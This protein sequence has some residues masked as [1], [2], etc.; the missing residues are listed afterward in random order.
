MQSKDDDCVRNYCAWIFFINST[1][2]FGHFLR[3]L[4]YYSTASVVTLTNP[5][6]ILSIISTDLMTKIDS[7]GQYSMY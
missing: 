4:A 5:L 3:H 6:P 2:N 1:L 7:L